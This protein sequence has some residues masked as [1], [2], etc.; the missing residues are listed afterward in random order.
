MAMSLVMFFIVFSDFGLTLVTVQRPQLAPEELNALF[1]ANLGFGIALA[2]LNAALAPAL[3]WFYDDARVWPICLL[4]S[5]F[6]LMAALGAQQQALLKRD[7][8]FRRLAIVRLIGGIAG[9]LAAILLALAGAGYWAL[10]A[11]MLVTATVT[12]AVAWIA[13]QWR[14]GLPRGCKGLRSM[15][16]FGGALTGHGVV[17]YFANNMDTVF[18]GKLAGPSAL[19]IYSAS[20]QAMMRPIALAAYGVGET[21]IPAM[22]RAGDPRSQRAIFRRMFSR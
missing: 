21:A 14:P 3:A 10:A 6:F 9:P 11:Q 18:L 17:G 7:M 12:T 16:G 2:A 1:W 19:G 8:K 15:L 5:T 22:S 13:V 4:L 20:Y